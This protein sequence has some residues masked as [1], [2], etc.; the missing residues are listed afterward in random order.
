MPRPQG[1]DPRIQSASSHHLLYIFWEGNQ[2][3][4]RFA[5]IG[6]NWED[7]MVSHVIPPDR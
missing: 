1:A 7:K 4:D 5:N 3:A 6:V 2:V